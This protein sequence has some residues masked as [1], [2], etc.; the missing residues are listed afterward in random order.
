MMGK[1]TLAQTIDPFPYKFSSSIYQKIKA[2]SASWLGGV[3]SSDLSFIGLY[4]EALEEC[5]KPRPFKIKISK[6]TV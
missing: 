1:S 5:D 4:K 6:R 3:T 2:D